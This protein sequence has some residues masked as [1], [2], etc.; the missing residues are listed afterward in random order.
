MRKLIY[1]S[2][3]LLCGCPN[4][5]TEVDHKAVISAAL[6]AASV[7]A[8]AVVEPD[9][10]EGTCPDCKGEGKVGDGVVMVDCQTCDGTGRIGQAAK[11]PS[12]GDAYDAAASGGSSI[13]VFHD[14]TDTMPDVY[15]SAILMHIDDTD[16]AIRDYYDLSTLPKAARIYGEDGT[17]KAEVFCP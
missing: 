1:V 8:A 14:G 6:G 3:L 2:A 15:P 12:Y 17:I 9:L 13:V 10:P 4:F 5:D 11:V 7:M 16:Q